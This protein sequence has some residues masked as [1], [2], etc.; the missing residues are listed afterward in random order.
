MET[1]RKC[2]EEGTVEVWD[3][4]R[5]QKNMLVNSLAD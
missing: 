1:N 3:T 2:S 5:K 4:F